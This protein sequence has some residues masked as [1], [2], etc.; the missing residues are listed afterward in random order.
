ML[1]FSILLMAVISTAIAFSKNSD[2]AEIKDQLVS[3]ILVELES[4]QNNYYNSNKEDDYRKFYGNF[5]NEDAGKAYRPKQKRFLKGIFDALFGTTTQKTTQKPTTTTKTT[6][7]KLVTVQ[8]VNSAASNDVFYKLK[9]HCDRSYD[10]LCWT[11]RQELLNLVKKCEKIQTESKHD[12]CIEVLSIY[13]YVFY[14]KSTC[15]YAKYQPYKPGQK[16]VATSSS[17]RGPIQI[18]VEVVTASKYTRPLTTKS[19][20][21]PKP[22]LIDSNSPFDGP[23]TSVPKDAKKLKEIGEYCLTNKN[24]NCD[25]MLALL[26]DKFTKCERRSKYDS[27]C[28][29]FKIEFCT[30]FKNFPCCPDVLAGR[31]CNGRSNNLKRS[32]LSL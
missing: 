25:K 32:Y 27:D 31:Q 23:V 14:E 9:V 17:T 30:A 28:Q 11:K 29:S 8:T 5:V 3:E 19:T 22:S 20:S 12:A 16:T 10:K 1:N 21:S 24:I 15:G 2:M 13:C 7:T 4:I 18:P 26:K 6:S